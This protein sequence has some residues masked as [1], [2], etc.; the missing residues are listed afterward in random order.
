MHISVTKWCIVWYGTGAL[1]D[2]C[3]RILSPLGAVSIISVI[4]SQVIRMRN[5]T[6]EIRLTDKLSYL[7]S[8]IAFT[9][10]RA[11]LCGNGTLMLL[12]FLLMKWD[13]EAG[14][15]ITFVPWQ[16]LFLHHVSTCRPTT[17]SHIL[18]LTLLCSQHCYV[19]KTQACCSMR[20]SNRTHM[21]FLSADSV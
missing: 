15:F 21:Q 11:S 6:L 7:N 17:H 18:F 8:R 20:I 16:V 10:K 4:L 3:H 13:R 2:L 1:C 14:F 12:G 19:H 5:P 9:G